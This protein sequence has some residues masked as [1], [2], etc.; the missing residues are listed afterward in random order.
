MPTQYT[1]LLLQAYLQDL[2]PG[3]EPLGCGSRLLE[4]EHPR[5][6]EFAREGEACLEALPARTVRRSGECTRAPVASSLWE[7]ARS[8]ASWARGE[9]TQE[10][11]RAATGRSFLSTGASERVGDR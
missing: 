4:G 2:L 6:G 9:S 1:L 3:D 8:M 7:R 11:V 10:G 5:D